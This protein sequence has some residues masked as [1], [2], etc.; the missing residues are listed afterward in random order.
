MKKS[1]PKTHFLKKTHKTRFPPTNKNVHLSGKKSP[2][3]IPP[4]LG[5]GGQGAGPG[6]NVNGKGQG[7]GPGPNVNGR[8]QGSGP[9]P[10]LNSKGQGAGPGPRLNGRG[11]GTG[12]GPRLN[13]RGQGAGPGPRLNMIKYGQ[14][15]SNMV[16][17]GWILVPK[18]VKKIQKTC[19]SRNDPKWYGNGSY[20]LWG[21]WERVLIM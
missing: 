11:Q 5:E 14:N 7:A 2:A 6:P 8:G 20:S 4:S 12:P 19:L 17:Y 1:C 21:S 9:G 16:Q 13:G 18:V 15:R 10:R 3:G